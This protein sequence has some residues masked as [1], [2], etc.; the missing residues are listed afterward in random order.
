MTA[1][2]GLPAPA[3]LVRV[4]RRLRSADMVL[5]VAMAVCVLLVCVAAAAPLLA[6]YD[7]AQT[8]VLAAGRSASAQH[9]L[10]T[11]S[12]GR[13]ILSR[14]LYGARL[15]LLGPALVVTV[16]TVAGTTLAIASVWYGGWF[17]RAITRLSD[18]L[19]AFPGLL[20]A[21]LAVA[22]FGSGLTAPVTALAIAYTPYLTR[23]VRSVAYRERNLP[24][25]EACELAGLSGW[26]I[27][28]RHL[29]PNL[30]PVIRAQA[31]I[32]FGTA[33]VELGAISYVGL[34]VQPPTTDWGLM[35]ADGQ[36]ALLNG[37]PQAALA[38]G[39]AIVVTVVAFNL[40]G[41]RLADRA[42]ANA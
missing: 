17:D 36:T 22:L 24:Y 37:R 7:P 38:A 11:D 12:L 25:I 8:D 6:P 41:E 23:I 34:G 19:F 32:S 29:L 30:L 28:T 31:V 21:V 39:L 4:T 35:I 2:T 15:S 14:L 1:L 20:F 5:V 18:V 3:P 40:L 9:W 10:G 42:E 33:L 27:C 13:D 16:A 26:R